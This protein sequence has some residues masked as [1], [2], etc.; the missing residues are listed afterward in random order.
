MKQLNIASESGQRMPYIGALGVAGTS[1]AFSVF[2]CLCFFFSSASLAQGVEWNGKVRG[3][4]TQT[5]TN[6]NSP[7]SL[8][9]K[10]AILQTTSTLE[11]E[12]NVQARYFTSKATVQEQKTGDGK[13]QNKA[14][15]NEFYVTSGDGAWQLSAGKKILDWDV[16]YAFRPN[17][18]VQQEQRRKL[19]NTTPVGKNM[20]AADYFTADFAAT[21][22]W[23]NPLKSTNSNQVLTDEEQAL[24]ARTYYRW[25][26]IDLYGF[27]RQGG[28]TGA[29]VGAA[30]AWV[31]TDALE[32]H[33][34]ARYVAKSRKP[35]LNVQS[36]VLNQRFPWNY[37]QEKN[38]TQ[39]LIGAT[40]T[41]EEQHSFILEAW[42]DG[43][44]LSSQQWRKW[45][46][47]NQDLSLIALTPKNQYL[48]AANLGWQNVAF[49]SATNLRRK[50]VFARWAWQQ[51]VW[52]PALDIIWTPE[53]KGRIVTASLGWQGDRVHID[54]G[55]RWYGGPKTA[56]IGQLSTSQSAYVTANWGF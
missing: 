36:V 45:T 23:V 38:L 43:T 20:I 39:A 33:A 32:L 8:L 1:L 22:V 47:R 50:N 48:L 53:D 9:S 4:L 51:A 15:F 3:L 21:L 2:A 42:W 27:A 26:G 12:L 41:T 25:H 44:A 56:I 28:Q 49:A 6:P 37:E 10:Q 52:Q 24:V 5:Q 40:W 46:V 7:N 14:W 19:T 11:G 29:S 16:A 34:S 35:V 30:L 54:G 18:M 13:L 31:A 17:D 55:V